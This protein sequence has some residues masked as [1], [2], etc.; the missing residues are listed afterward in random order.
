MPSWTPFAA[1]RS[2]PVRVTGELRMLLHGSP[3]L[4]DVALHCQVGLVRAVRQPGYHCFA[5]M[6]P[7]E[8]NSFYN[9]RSSVL[10]LMS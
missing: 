7:D 1:L 5:F 6:G 3:A 9:L 2:C 10:K 8:R 4:D